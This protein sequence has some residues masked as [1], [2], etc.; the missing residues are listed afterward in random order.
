M[1]SFLKFFIPS[2]FNFAWMSVFGNSE[3]VALAAQTLGARTLNP[4]SVQDLM[5]GKF[6]DAMRSTSAGMTLEDLQSKGKEFTDKVYKLTENVVTKNGLELESVSLSR[7]DQTSKKFFDPGN[8]F[9]AEGLI[10]I[11][12][13]TEESRKKITKHKTLGFK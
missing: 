13:E 11:T 12:E 8:T 10:K 4:K 5:E 6:V 2:L 9:D 1:P 7:L 3:S